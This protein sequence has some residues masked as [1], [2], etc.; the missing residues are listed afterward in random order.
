MGDRL[1][2]GIPPG[3]VA[4][5]PGQLSLAIPLWVG[6]VSIG[7]VSTGDGFGHCKGRNSEFCITVDH[8]TRTV[9]IPIFSPVLAYLV[10][11]A[12]AGSKCRKKG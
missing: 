1:R 2:A 8:V 7:A 4:S 3:Y 9:G 11:A 5:H 10:L 6:A 12:F